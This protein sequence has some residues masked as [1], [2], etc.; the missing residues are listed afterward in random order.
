MAFLVHLMPPHMVVSALLLHSFH[1]INPAA[2]RGLHAFSFR[3]PATAHKEEINNNR[4]H[5]KPEQDIEKIYWA[6]NCPAIKEN[7]IAKPDKPDEPLLEAP[8]DSLLES[9]PKQDQVS[10]SEDAPLPSTPPTS[11]PATSSEDPFG[12][13]K[14]IDGIHRF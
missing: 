14:N 3:G 2:N 12:G 5:S 13:G 10:L 6:K 1:N 7:E 9:P 8:H 11:P 4:A